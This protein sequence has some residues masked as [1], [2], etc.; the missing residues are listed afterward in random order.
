ML[1][2]QIWASHHVMFDHIGHAGRPVLFLNTVLLMD[3]AFLPF[4]AAVLGPFVSPRAGGAHR[5]RPS[6]HRVRT[7]RCLVQRHLVVRPA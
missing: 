4:A 5:R 6:R 2:G 1:I 7:G 3:I